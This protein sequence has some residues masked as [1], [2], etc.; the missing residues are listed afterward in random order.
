MAQYGKADYWEA[1]YTKDPDPFDWYQSY[2]SSPAMRDLIRRSV[3]SSGTILVPGCGSSRLSED[4]L[5]DGYVNGIVSVDQS[6]TV[7]NALEDR[8]K[9]QP[10]LQCT[11]WRRF[12][13]A[14]GPPAPLSQPSTAPS[15]LRAQSEL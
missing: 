14:R 6:L 9:G 3:P 12:A 15:P 13:P 8:L 11:W 2:A 5:T 7:I 1:R 4:M 10:S